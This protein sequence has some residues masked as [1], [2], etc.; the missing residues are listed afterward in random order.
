MGEHARDDIAE[1]QDRLEQRYGAER[2]ERIG[3][4]N[5]NML[6]Y[7]NLV[8]NDIMAVTVRT[9]YPTGP[10]EMEVIGWAVA[11]VDETGERLQSRLRNFLEFLGPGGFATPDD[12]EALESCQVGFQAGGVEWN[13]VSRG[14]NREQPLTDDELQMRVFWRQW[15]AQMAGHQLANWDDQKDPNRAL[16]GS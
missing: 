7:P 8:I 10:G 11:P 12:L 14:M 9:F 16:V 15:K 1:T 4:Y 13:D 5:R 2:A 3:Q 6:I